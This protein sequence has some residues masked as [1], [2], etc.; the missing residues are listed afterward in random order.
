MFIHPNA[1]DVSTDVGISGTAL[2]IMAA[3]HENSFAN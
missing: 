2:V 1:G 3:P